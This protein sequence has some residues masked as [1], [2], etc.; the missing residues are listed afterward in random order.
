[1]CFDGTFTTKDCFNGFIAYIDGH[2]FD[3]NEAMYYSSMASNSLFMYLLTCPHK[4]QH[5]II[6]AGAYMVPGEIITTQK[7]IS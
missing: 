4:I 1:M 3:K 6:D 7:A 5:V 2:F